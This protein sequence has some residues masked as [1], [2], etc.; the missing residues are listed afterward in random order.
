MGKWPERLN[1]LRRYI[2]RGSVYGDMQQAL[3]IIKRD[4]EEGINR[5]FGVKFVE[6]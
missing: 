1:K 5:E 6:W 2:I 3:A 4:V